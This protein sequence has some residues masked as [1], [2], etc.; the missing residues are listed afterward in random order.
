[1]FRQTSC[2][3]IALRE[4]HSTVMAHLHCRRRT[5]VQTRIRIPNLMATLYYAGHVHIAHSQTQIPTIYFCTETESEYES[6][7]DNL[8]E[9]LDY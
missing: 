8:N 9:P 1:M 7:P 5:Q 4:L 3:N 2:K 6:V